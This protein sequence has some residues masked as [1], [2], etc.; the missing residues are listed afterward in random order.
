MTK[1]QLLNS[2]IKMTK[3]TG[4]GVPYF[5]KVKS[6]ELGYLLDEL[7]QEGLITYSKVSY[8]DSWWTAA[9]CYNVWHDGRGDELT[10]IRVYLGIDDLGLGVKLIDILSNL[11]FMK[12]YV[13]WLDKNILELEKLKNLEEVEEKYEVLTGDILEYFLE[14]KCVK[15]NKTIENVKS[16]LSER[17]DLTTKM[18]GIHEQIINLSKNSN[19]HLTNLN[20]SKNEKE[21]CENEIKLIKSILNFLA[22]RK[23]DDL[24][25]SI[26]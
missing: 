11:D 13:D 9:N 15:D 1:T 17:L 2:V 16:F 22:G 19:K 3:T 24:I 25:K 14:L 20:K 26:L 10:F 5:L 18:I 8:S 7:T 4:Q 23:E 6:S 12:K 21:E